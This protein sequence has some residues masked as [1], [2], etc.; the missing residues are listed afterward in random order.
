MITVK[1]GVSAASTAALLALAALQAAPAMADHHADAKKVHCW[2][3]N[4]CKGSSDCKTAEHAC[5]GQ[6]ACKGHGFKEMSADECTKAG[7]KTEAKKS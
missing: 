1:T 5:K 3:V 7:G 4:S 6:N 2:G